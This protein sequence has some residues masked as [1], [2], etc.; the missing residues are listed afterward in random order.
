VRVDSHVYANYFVPSNY[1]SM[2]GKIIVHGDTREQALAR[3][4]TALAE[5]VVE[6][7][8]TNIPL[9]RELM[10]DANFEAGGTNIHYLEEWLAQRQR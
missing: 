7:I 8:S 10:V 2:I 4:R 9:H 6:G 5:T 3:M 1:D